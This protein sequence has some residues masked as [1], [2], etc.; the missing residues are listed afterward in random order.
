MGAEL[1]SVA[2]ICRKYLIAWISFGLVL[3]G[4]AL[5]GQSAPSAQDISSPQFWLARVV[6]VTDQNTDPKVI[7][8][9]YSVIAPLQARAGD[10]AG[11]RR[12]LE[13][14]RAAEN[15]SS[16]K[17][18]IWFR[19]A[20]LK[21]YALA[22]DEADFRARF[23]EL[24]KMRK[25]DSK[26]FERYN[27]QIV[28]ELCD[29]GRLDEALAWAELPANPGSRWWYLATVASAQAK[30]GNG[31]ACGRTLDLAE[32][33]AES[34]TRESPGDG[35]Y[36]WDGLASVAATT[37]DAKRL[38]RFA[39]H[40]KADTVASDYATLAVAEWD[41]GN[42]TAC[43]ADMKNAMDLAA[44]S[45]PH[46][47][48]SCYGT[49][50]R[51]RAATGDAAGVAATEAAFPVGP[52]LS[53]ETIKLQD[54]YYAM[55]GAYAILGDE[56]KVADRLKKAQDIVGQ[57]NEAGKAL[58]GSLDDVRAMMAPPYPPI[59]AALARKGKIDA[60]AK[61]AADAPPSQ[62]DGAMI[63]LA[64]VDA[65]IGR[66][67]DAIK[68]LKSRDADEAHLVL[69][70]MGKAIGMSGKLRKWLDYADGLKSAEDRGNAYLGAAEGLL[71]GAQ[72]R[73]RRQ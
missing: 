17:E 51:A 34:A 63:A 55:A 61:L 23:D 13:K 45:D 39:V 52:D 22:K 44:R 14:M 9:E 31:D 67:D 33:D 38:A 69:F 56:A 60:A 57:S 16:P 72:G 36:D 1:E 18:R 71:D 64:L 42:K 58:Q 3:L 25:A 30:A 73:E 37:G 10:V 35:D 48:G 19:I 53:K 27:Y 49:I 24:R 8:N 15:T 59:L 7:A 66:T 5:P 47:L 6:A 2:M 43:A 50:A 40:L 32:P 70:A 68:I 20:E 46:D 21:S 65:Q 62:R 41:A 26:A 54:F 4:A 12:S 11:M 29:I 28:T